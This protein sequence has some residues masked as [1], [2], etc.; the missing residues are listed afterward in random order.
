[1]LN[2]ILALLCVASVMLVIVSISSSL[3]AIQTIP[4]NYYQES[5]GIVPSC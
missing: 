3:L 4:K 5:K 2:H 1:M